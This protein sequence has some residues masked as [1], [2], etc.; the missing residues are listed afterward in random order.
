MNRIIS[1]NICTEDIRTA[2]CSEK[3]RYRGGYSFVSHHLFEPQ[4]Q[5]SRVRLLRSVLHKVPQRPR[6]RMASRIRELFKIKD[7]KQAQELSKKLF[8]EFSSLIPNAFGI[9]E[10]GWAY[11]IRL[12]HFPK[13]H[14]QQ[15]RTKRPVEHTIQLFRL[16]HCHTALA[17]EVM[18]MNTS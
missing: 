16:F 14:W 12:C 10:R 7:L 13:Q 6:K 2:A 18:S 3:K 9:L 8:S 15:I 11:A 17:K 5:S 4:R 1:V